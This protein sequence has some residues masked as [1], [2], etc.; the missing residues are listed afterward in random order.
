MHL[1]YCVYGLMVACL[2]YWGSSLV[3]AQMTSRSRVPPVSIVYESETGAGRPRVQVAEFYRE[4]GSK[5]I[6]VQSEGDA[7]PGRVAV[8]DIAKKRHFVKDPVTRQYDE[9]P[10]TTAD[11]K[12]LL[13]RPIACSE[14]V[15]IH[16]QCEPA[17]GEPPVYLGC[18]VE[19]GTFPITNGQPMRIAFAPDL[20]YIPLFRRSVSR[21][22]STSVT[23]ATRIVQGD[24]D[25]SLF[26]LPPDYTK[27]ESSSEFLIKGQLARGEE[28][29]FTTDSAAHFD[30]L[31]EEKRARG[32]N[33][34][35]P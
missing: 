19:W 2:G 20:A 17:A 14:A 15:G 11:V 10:F 16:G 1:R 13:S 18:R 7:R 32:K 21:D 26:E 9:F 8:I 3:H 35:S 12:P 5:A 34:K 30:Q 23:Q 22:G 6:A 4:D 33:K 24:P 25:P 28:T 31:Q 27:A 29:G